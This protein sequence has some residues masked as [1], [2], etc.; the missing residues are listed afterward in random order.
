MNWL[1]GKKKEEKKEDEFTGV[2]IKIDKSKLQGLQSV[3]GLNLPKKPKFKTKQEI[4]E[5]RELKSGKEAFDL[6]T[7]FDQSTY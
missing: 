6:D 7:E 2:T 3:E 5:E 1:F 4:E